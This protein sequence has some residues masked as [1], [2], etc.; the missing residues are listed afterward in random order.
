MS[1][2]NNFGGFGNGFGGG[3]I[4]IILIIIILLFWGCNGDSSPC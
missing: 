2:G 3:G 4:I 1:F